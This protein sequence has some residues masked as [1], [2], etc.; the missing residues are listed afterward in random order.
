MRG[1]TEQ[2]NNLSKKQMAK[3]Q[4][5]QRAKCGHSTRVATY[6]Y[7]KLLIV[8][9]VMMAAHEKPDL[10]EPDQ[11]VRLSLEVTVAHLPLTNRDTYRA[12][13]VD[14]RLYR[15]VGSGNHKK[16]VLIDAANTAEVV[17]SMTG[18]I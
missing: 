12:E 13:V 16:L 8:N 11:K 17:A 2:L 1:Y 5:K 4:A 6:K 3:R 9:A 15:S 7:D 10:A 14:G 18:C